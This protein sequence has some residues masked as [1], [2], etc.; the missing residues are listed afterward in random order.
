MYYTWD[1]V[2]LYFRMGLAYNKNIKSVLDSETQNQVRDIRK[3]Y[4]V[5]GDFL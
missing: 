5:R 4:S 3:D 2:E 1:F